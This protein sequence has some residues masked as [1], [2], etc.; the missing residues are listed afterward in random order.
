LRRT[1]ERQ[2][3]ACRMKNQCVGCKAPLN[4]ESDGELLYCINC[5]EV[6]IREPRVTRA[7]RPNYR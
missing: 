5:R 4:I 1:K 7:R 2:K 3:E 6:M